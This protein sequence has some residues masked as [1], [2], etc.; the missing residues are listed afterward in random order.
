MFARPERT[1]GH[2]DS[3]GSIESLDDPLKLSHR[4]LPYRPHSSFF[5]RSINLIICTLLIIA[6]CQID[7]TTARNYFDNH[8]NYNGR[9]E[10][11]Q[12]SFCRDLPYNQ[13]ILPNLFNHQSQ[14][15]ARNHLRVYEPL[16]KLK[17]S[18]YLQLFLCTLY[19]PI[20]LNNKE[21]VPPCRNLCLSAKNGCE[22]H[23]PS[24]WEKKFNCSNFPLFDN[25]PLC[26]WKPDDYASI[27]LINRER[28]LEDAVAKE[29]LQYF[30]SSSRQLRFS[31]P[32]QFRTPSKR[33]HVFNLNGKK[34]SDCATPCDLYL[35]REQT[36]IVRYWSGFWSAVC[37]I[38]S[39]FTFLTFFID[40]QR[41]HYP[42]KQIIFISLCYIFI[43]CIY[44]VGFLTKD[45]IACTPLLSSLAG[46]N[47]LEFIKSVTQGSSDNAYCTLMA[48]T[49][50]YF[51]MASAIWF[52]LLTVSW[53]IQTGPKWSYEGIEKNA[54][55]YHLIAWTVPAIK[56]IVLVSKNQLEGDQLTG[57]CYVGLLDRNNLLGYLFWPL[58]VYLSVGMVFLVIVVVELWKI[59]QMLVKN[60]DT[61]RQ[62]IVM[63]KIVLFGTFYVIPNLI[64]ITCYLIEY[65]RIDNWS[66]S[67][68]ARSCSNKA[69]GIP[70][71][72]LAPDE[73]ELYRPS[74]AL[75]LIKYLAL[76]A[77]GI[78]SGIWIWS[79]KTLYS[80]QTELRTLK[81][82][83]M[84]KIFCEE[85]GDEV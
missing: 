5:I 43:S 70:C 12:I 81:N 24:D 64:L 49:L 75:F 1:A 61:E 38:S 40:S 65:Y 60:Q 79:H 39:L 32:I 20:C 77:P 62:R 34:Y 46:D 2:I 8:L 82:N 41:F 80:W 51:T 23:I 48:M 35:N 17:C 72:N 55:Y 30:N 56:T 19:A 47:N 66:L 10:E 85:K 31:C 78:T 54:H 69:Y 4:L 27:S 42:E 59:R 74:L 53:Y 37:L 33:G 21:P 16:I 29:T 57:V 76:L 3:P 52:V 63:F 9:C 18:P 36:Q 50:Y 28:S 84:N 25:Q 44:F 67:W 6:T 71:P 22:E 45:Q 68:L 15:I 14:D 58:C 26:I 7:R 73:E 11:I 13:T 83:L